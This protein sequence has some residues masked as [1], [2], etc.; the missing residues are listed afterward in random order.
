MN[1]FFQTKKKK[2]LF[3]HWISKKTKKLLVQQ[4][5]REQK[6]G[7]RFL[8]FCNSFCLFRRQKLF[9]ENK[10][11]G[12]VF[13]FVFFLLARSFFSVLNPMCFF[14]F[15]SFS[16]NF[17]K[18]VLKVLLLSFELNGGH[19]DVARENK[20]FSFFFW[21]NQKQSVFVPCCWWVM[22]TD[23]NWWVGGDGVFFILMTWLHRGG[24]SLNFTIFVIRWLRNIDTFP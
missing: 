22:T 14:L 23:Y 10:A 9:L 2:E 11:K 5:A 21:P 6:A 17:T 12:K 3:C 15:F 19:F 7:L 18:Q 24:G 13:C 20:N 1:I 8:P 16:N 4:D